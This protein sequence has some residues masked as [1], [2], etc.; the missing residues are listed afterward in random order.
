MPKLA[1]PTRLGRFLPIVE[2]ELR[3]AARNNI[4]YRWRT[5]VTAV[6][7]GTMGLLTVT[8]S[9]SAMSPQVQGISLFRVLVSLSSLYAFLGSVAV[10]AD[11]ISREKREGTLG[12]LFL[13]DLR[14]R[15]VVIGKLAAT[16]LHTIYGLLALLPLLGIPVLMGGVSVGAGISAALSVINLL[17][18]S[19][20]LGMFVSTH[21]WNERRA[22]F[23]AITA[24]LAWNIGPILLAS[25][26]GQYS[27][28]LLSI[29]PLWPFLQSVGPLASTSAMAFL[30]SHLIGWAL[31]LRACNQAQSS[32]QSRSGS[33]VR[34]TIDERIF[35]SENPE[36][37][38]K[39]RRGMLD[40]HPI[41]WLL[42]RHPGK[43]FYAD[44][45]V[46]S[47]IIIWVVGYQTYGSGMFGGPGWF[48]V[49][50]LAFAI[51]LILASWVVAESS[52]KLLEDRRSGA[53]ELLLC[54]SLTDRELIRGHRLALRRLFFRPV[55]ILVIAEVF[56]AFQGFGETDAG[57]ENGR[58][59]ML[60][61]AAAVALDLYALSWISLRLATSLPNV[62]RV[63]ILALAITPIGP[64]V[65]PI[66][67]LAVLGFQ[68]V[69]FI[70][71]L[72]IW[73]A[74]ML[75]IDLIFGCW[76]CRSSLLHH[77]RELASRVRPRA[78]GASQ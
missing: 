24:G 52:M 39:H 77:F 15:D 3:L 18:V 65:L 55:T 4:I 29:S 37:R 73:F 33:P 70:G 23:A 74:T 50:P 61:M 41:V 47:V 19:L 22:L 1:I 12:L 64:A 6:G 36:A 44:I 35:T 71:V 30:P 46:V 62:N 59:L 60:A 32:W 26:I 13:T 9:A 72:A 16:S 69:T 14:G 27:Q 45:L 54:T 17:F 49:A 7:L 53:L 66:L 5:I 8:Q 28:S 21:S 51:H 48:L 67:I 43:R 38:R 56:V 75:A 63:G 42:E 11:T 78:G 58:W 2:R 10:T 40:A 76:I 68:G 20:S 57:A 34:R 25:F 31:L